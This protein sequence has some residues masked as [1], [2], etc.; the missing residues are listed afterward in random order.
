MNADTR[1]EAGKHDVQSRIGFRVS[2]LQF[3]GHDADMR[4]KIPNIPAVAAED[5]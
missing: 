2:H 1:Q 5:S 4:T 3:V